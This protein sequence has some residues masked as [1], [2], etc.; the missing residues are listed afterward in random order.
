MTGAGPRTS[1]TFI[2]KFSEGAERYRAAR[3]TYPP[4]LFAVL[5]GL[6]PGRGLAW[7]CGTGSGQ[8]A[9]GL[10]AW[11]ERVLA[12]DP[13]AEQIA[14]AAPAERVEYRVER[15]ESVS[16]ADGA[17]DLILAAQALHWFDLDTF[18]AEAARVLR[19][20]GVLAAIGYDWMYVSPE[21]DRVVGEQL[22]PPLRFHWA[23][24][25][26]LLWDG[27]RSIPFPGEEI[28]I[29]P[30]AIHLEW[31]FEEAWAYVR[32]WSAV[33]ALIA[34]EGEAAIAGAAAALKSAWGEGRRHVVMPLHVRV[35]RL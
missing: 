12:T 13:S 8:A 26:R 27:Y 22:L 32:S 2:D 4:E 16:L 7:D 17:A 25:N 9:A 31:R 6:A 20:S 15:A 14:N 33:G 29:G 5:A 30:F 35:A 34:A 18:Y 24:Q 19:P 10:A 23:P 3:P 21:V 28:R 1:G 11:F